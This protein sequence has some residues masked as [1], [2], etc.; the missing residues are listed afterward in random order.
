MQ[1]T[2][3]KVKKLIADDLSRV[4]IVNSEWIS[5]GRVGI[6][7]TNITNCPKTLEAWQVVFPNITEV[8]VPETVLPKSKP[9][10]LYN[11]KI[12]WSNDGF[13]NVFFAD[14]NDSYLTFI[15]A[16]YVEMLDISSVYGDISTQGKVLYENS[17][18]SS[19]F[20]M[21]CI[22]PK[23]LNIAPFRK[24]YGNV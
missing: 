9:H 1:F 21:P 5:N 4:C 2:I 6:R 22:I 20:V 24:V 12:S 17:Q 15:S 11:T 23:S 14:D 3:Q 19:F 7:L 16:K 13:T 8:K 18:K 10:H